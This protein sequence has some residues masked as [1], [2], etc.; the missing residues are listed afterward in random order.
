MF[1]ILFNS[2]F[3]I[4]LMSLFNITSYAATDEEVASDEETVKQIADHFVKVPTMA[5]EFIQFDPNGRQTGGKF[6]IQRPGKIRFNYQEPTPLRIISNGKTVAVN[7]RK[8]KTWSFYP[9]KKTPLS[10]VLGDKLAIDIENVREVRNDTDLTTLVLGDDKIF[11][12]SEIT[13]MFDPRTH[14]LRQWVIRD[15]QGKETTVMIFNVQ[16]NVEIPASYFKVDQLA[17]QR[18]QAVDR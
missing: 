14:D 9:L 17:I 6:F 5:G 11:G 8:L 1:R 15:A 10:L 4:I 13:M 16:K 3:A 2:F 12:D 18:G 7:N